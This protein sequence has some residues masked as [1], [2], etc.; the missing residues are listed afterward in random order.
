M[1]RGRYVFSIFGAF[2]AIL[3]GAAPSVAAPVDD[4][5]L[6]AAADSAADW[7]TFGHDYTNQRFSTLDEIDRRTVARLSLAWEHNTGAKGPFQTQPLV[8]DGV[9]V[10]TTPGNHVTALDGATGEV[11]WHYEHVMRVEKTRGGPTNRGAAIGHG[12]IFQATNDGR[13]I[14]LDRETGDLVWDSLLATPAPGEVEALAALGPEIQQAFVDGVGSFPA[15]MPPLVADGKV[16]AGVISAGYGLYQDLGQELGFGGPPE[17]ETK[18]GRRGYLAA[19]D[20]VTGAEIWRWHT[21]KADGWEG[22]FSATTVD[23]AA[24]DRDLDAE[25]TAAPA[26]ADAWRRG[27]G[28]TWMTPSYD[29]ELGL[30]FLGTGNP[31]P[32]DADQLRPG[33]NLYTSSLVALDIATGEVRWHYQVVPHDIWGYDV[34]N[35]PLL[36]SI[37]TGYDAT[38]AVGVGAKTGWYYAVHRKT[39]KLLFKSEALVPQSNMFSR[40]SPEGTAYA[41]G[42][43]GGISWSPSAYHPG[44]GFIYVSAIH[45]PATLFEKTFTDEVS[46]ETVS[47]LQTEYDEAGESWGTLSAINTRRSGEIVWQVKTDRPL[48]GGVLATAG[49]LIFVGEGNGRFNAFDAETGTRLW[50]FEAG[51][52]INAPPL[53]YQAGG[54]Q[55]V[56]IA[57]GGSRFYGF[58]PGDSLLAF[59]LPTGE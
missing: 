18:N 3:A 21:T 8:V 1:T 48:V 4:A 12:K 5:R 17:V 55:Y 10:I 38:P 56:A 58:A 30:I 9:M 26:H 15:K 51:P 24:L 50:Q 49:D 25:K 16:I 22:E 47:F 27:G 13:L 7:L 37:P 32:S 34:A 20:A 31:S 45:K 33:D 52:G 42:S 11:L 35:A 39:G 59:A 46:G 6:L 19:F 40:G 57:A 2:A 44:T 23:G 54:R 41:P 53:T 29:P 36:F 28:S 14:A 43:F